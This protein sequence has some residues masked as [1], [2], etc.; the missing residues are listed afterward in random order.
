[1]RR[2]SLNPPQYV[3]S[4]WTAL[5]AH[6]FIESRKACCQTIRSTVAK[7]KPGRVV[8]IGSWAGR[9]PHAPIP[10][11]CIA[12][13]RTARAGHDILVNEVAPGNVGGGLSQ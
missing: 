4:A 9:T 13:G 11:Y 8:F 12:K 1:M 2:A 5:A 7:K 6:F 10:T 3:S